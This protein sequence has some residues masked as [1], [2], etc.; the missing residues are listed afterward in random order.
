MEAIFMM[1]RRILEN[2]DY[3]YYLE[4]INEVE[5][6]RIYCRHGLDHYLAVAKISM[7]LAR[8]CEI[9]VDEDIVYGAALLHDLGRYDIEAKN[10]EDV[11][12][13]LAE[14]ILPDCGYEPV[15]IRVIVDLI[16]SHRGRYFISEI[17]HLRKTK[18][19]DLNACF[20]IADQ[21]SR[22]C[23]ECQAVD[24]CKWKEEEKIKFEI[25]KLQ[26]ET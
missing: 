23:F 25:V 2:R 1:Y 26:G 9:D 4:Q 17:Q 10:H 15:K 19:L 7:L 14:K 20:R 5:K 18:Q 21:I 22:K 11:S 13:Q 24:T 16:N 12:C 3:K 8:E 6:D